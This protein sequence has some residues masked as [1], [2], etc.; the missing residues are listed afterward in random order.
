HKT[1]QATMGSLFHV[2]VWI[3]ELDKAIDK[4]SFDGYTIMATDTQG[5]PL[6]S[7]PFPGK[8]AVILG[9]EANGI[10]EELKKSCHQTLYIP[11]HGK[12]ESLNV[13][14]AGTLVCYEMAKKSM[15]VDK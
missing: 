6:G 5:A 4:L 12:A 15:R 3:H 7:Y 9:N 1:I 11:D 13:A 10:S 14:M 8:S 2:N